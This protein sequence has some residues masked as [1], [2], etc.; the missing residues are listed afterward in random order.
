MTYKL[1]AAALLAVALAWCS[2]ARAAQFPF[3]IFLSGPSEFPTNTSPGTGSGTLLY[4]DVAH[5]LAMN[6]SFSGLIGNTTAAHIHAPTA[7]P[8]TTPGIGGTEA[9][10]SAAMGASVATTLPSFVG[11]PLGVKSGTFNNTLDLTQSSSWN[12]SYVTNNG[13][14]PASAEV[15]FAT[16]LKEGRAYFNIHT[17]EFGGGEI[18]GFPTLVPEPSTVLLC[19]MACAPL[20]V[21]RRHRHN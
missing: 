19:L 21:R 16:A 9:Q 14:T 12:P 17:S 7:I 3:T 10:A 11:F 18:R 20:V 5:T 8:G 6:I 4:D 13:G 15:A 1:G 2:A